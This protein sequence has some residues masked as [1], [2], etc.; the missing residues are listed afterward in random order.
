MPTTP[1]ALAEKVDRAVTVARD[2][3][4]FASRRAL[5]LGSLAWGLGQSLGE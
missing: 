3:S 4:V 1:A 2:Y 5:H